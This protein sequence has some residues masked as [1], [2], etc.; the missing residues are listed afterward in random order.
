[1]EGVGL[2]VGGCGG[3]NLLFW[4]WR[5]GIVWGIYF[6]LVVFGTGYGGDY[7]VLLF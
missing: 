1:M 5:E 6:F 2:E 7:G 3:F 4:G